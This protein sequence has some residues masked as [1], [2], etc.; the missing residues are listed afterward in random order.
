[1]MLNLPLIALPIIVINQLIISYYS[2]FSKTRAH[3]GFRTT[4]M[5]GSDALQMLTSVMY[6]IFHYAPDDLLVLHSSD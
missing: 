2:S 3:F 6:F 5:K 1:M 4:L